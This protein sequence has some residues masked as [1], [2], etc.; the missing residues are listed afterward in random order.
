MQLAGAVEVIRWIG[1]KFRAHD[2]Q[3][4]VSLPAPMRRWLPDA[5]LALFLRVVGGGRSS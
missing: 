2:L 5:L 3:Q 4:P 1:K